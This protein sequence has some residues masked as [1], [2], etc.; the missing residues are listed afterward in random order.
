M[1]K[2]NDFIEASNEV[3]TERPEKNWAKN[4]EYTFRKWIGPQIHKVK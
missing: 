4:I 3:C 2:L 1:V